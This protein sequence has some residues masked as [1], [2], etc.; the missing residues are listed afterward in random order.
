MKFMIFGGPFQ[1]LIL[2]LPAPVL[3]D[4]AHLEGI[5]SREEIGRLS[6][7]PPAVRSGDSA[8]ARMGLAGGGT[9]AGKRNNRAAATPGK[10]EPRGPGRLLRPD[11]PETLGRFI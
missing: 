9:G 1:G 8:G 5:L 7:I 4:F 2:V 11:Q 3:G 10:L 6:F